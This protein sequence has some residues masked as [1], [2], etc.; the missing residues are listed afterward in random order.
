M[1]RNKCRRERQGERCRKHYVVWNEAET[2]RMWAILFVGSVRGVEETGKWE[3][4]PY[5]SEVKAFKTKEDAKLY[6]RRK[7][8][9][10][11]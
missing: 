6:I 8:M 11:V 1:K 9:I 2:T 7:N 3:K 4:N 5:D 10:C